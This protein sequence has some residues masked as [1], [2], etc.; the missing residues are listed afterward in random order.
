[1]DRHWRGSVN[2]FDDRGTVRDQITIHNDLKSIEDNP[3]DFIMPA[4][5][6]VQQEPTGFENRTDSVI[7]WDDVTRT[8]TIDDAG[9]TYDVW[10][11]GVGFTKSG[12]ESIQPPDVEGQHWFYF[13]DSGVLQTV[14]SA[15]GLIETNPLIAGVYWDATNSK[16]RLYEERHGHRMAG[17]THAY[18]HAT[19]GA[20]WHA[21]AALANITADGSGNDA[22]HAQFSLEAGS[23]ADEDNF[24]SIAQRSFPASTRVYYKDGPNG[25]WRWDDP[26]TYPVKSFVG[27][28]GRLAWNEFTGSTWQQK[29]VGNNRFCLVHI[30]LVNDVDD[31]VAI[32]QGQDDYSNIGAARDGAEV[33]LTN[34]ILEGLPGA[35]FCPI[36]TLIWQ[37]SSSYSN[38]PKARIRTTTEGDDYIDWRGRT[39]AAG[40]GSAGAP[41]IHG[42]DHVNGTDDVPDFVGDSGAGG[43]KGLVPAPAAGDGA[44][45]KALKAD[46][47][48]GVVGGS[49]PDPVSSA[50][51]AGN[52]EIAEFN[53]VPS[54]WL[55]PGMVFL[56]EN[57]G[58]PTAGGGSDALVKGDI[59]EYDGANW[60]KVISA[61]GGFPPAGTRLAVAFGDKYVPATNNQGKIAVFSGTSLTPTFEDPVEG[62]V[63][64]VVD[65]GNLYDRREIIKRRTGI[66][67]A[68]V[69]VSPMIW[70]VRNNV[71]LIPSVVFPSWA[72]IVSFQMNLPR[73]EYKI[74]WHAVLRVSDDS[75]GAYLR[76]R[77]DDSTVIGPTIGYYHFDTPDGSNAIK[78]P[79]FSGSDTITPSSDAVH[80]FDLDVAREHTDG[81]VWMYFAHIT[82]EKIQA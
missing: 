22:I 58:T 57:A 35:E 72:E 19:R 66:S 74:A 33:E 76:V 26:S 80:K 16:A 29:E 69:D 3:L 1:M 55:Y 79:P 40:S 53:A 15:E 75:H 59:A 12:I 13:D 62:T 48:W 78:R 37:T 81:Q 24:H 7:S 64:T 36:A 70:E 27:G 17:S 52:R 4:F 63:L 51:Y 30:F 82:V 65:V 9:S 39:L 32:I 5:G 73:G 10:V 20:R 46:G 23:F 6:S 34:L 47:T 60:R 38:V 44:A 49:G 31:D 71:L 2:W 43:T 61:A 50:Y 68:W 42:A 25:Y 77:V 18:L 56:A 41:S 8:F 11:R 54:G 28:S 14:V 21:G 67:G 45:G